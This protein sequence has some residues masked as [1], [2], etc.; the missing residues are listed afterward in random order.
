MVKRSRSQS[1]ETPSRA[2]W[3]V[4]VEPDSRRHDQTRSMNFSRP[5]ARRSIRGELTLDDVLG[6]NARV[7]GTRNPGRDLTEHAVVAAED[8]L[9]RVVERMAHVQR[10]SDVG[11]RDDHREGLPGTLLV[12]AEVA[13]IAPHAVPTLLHRCGLVGLGEVH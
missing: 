7:I 6:S 5:I 2:S 3:R 9:D 1:Q 8:V 13:A 11:R 4:I 10:P 12:A